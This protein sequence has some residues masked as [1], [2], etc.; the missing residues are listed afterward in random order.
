MVPGLRESVGR[1]LEIVRR[2]AKLVPL[3]NIVLGGI[4][5]GCATAIFALLSSGLELGGFVG[6]CSWLP[7]QEE[8]EAIA[9]DTENQDND[10]AQ[11]TR[12]I[13]QIGSDEDLEGQ[14]IR[15]D[16]KVAKTGE[17]AEDLGPLMGQLSLSVGAK[18]KT[19]IFLAHSRDD[20]TVPF[21]M[22]EGLCRTMKA[23]GF[24]VRWQEYEDGGHWIH[25]SKGV[26]DMA[27]FLHDMLDK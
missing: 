17:G 19:P 12:K 20:E 15:G 10:V 14:D 7:F 13:L 9:H 2:E 26:D 8:I 1:V 3:R 4:S 11:R 27:N 22:G 21:D 5:Q 16:D 18:G 23:L 25:P 6:L 24:D